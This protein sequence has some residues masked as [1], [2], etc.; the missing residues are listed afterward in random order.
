MEGS[1]ELVAGLSV[2]RDD[3]S[4]KLVE[5]QLEKMVPKEDATLALTN[6]KMLKDVDWNSER[7]RRLKG[8]AGLDS[9]THAKA[10]AELNHGVES[11]TAKDV[12]VLT[13]RPLAEEPQ[14]VAGGAIAAK[15]YISDLRAEL[16]EKENHAIASHVQ[17]QGKTRSRPRDDQA[18]KNPDPTDLHI[19]TRLTALDEQANAKAFA[20]HFAGN[21]KLPRCHFPSAS[22][23][24]LCVGPSSAMSSLLG[25]IRAEIP[26]ATLLGT[27]C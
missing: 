20:A 9:I 3:E 6:A 13:N 17:Y 11:Q 10:L 25:S 15:D 7:I 22:N 23:C 21:A 26:S 19:N 5:A 12:L 8:N 14:A 4:F 2:P 18:R 1:H 24:R 16:I 27:S